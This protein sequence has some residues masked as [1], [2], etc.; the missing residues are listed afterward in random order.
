MVVSELRIAAWANKVGQDWKREGRGAPVWRG[1]L[2][3]L[4]PCD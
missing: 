1:S 4:H 3:F 2:E